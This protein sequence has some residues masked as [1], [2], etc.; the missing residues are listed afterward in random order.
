[1]DF[2]TDL[3]QLISIGAS[4]YGSALA[5]RRQRTVSRRNTTA[6]ASPSLSGRATHERPDTGGERA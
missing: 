3:L 6:P 5:I 1:L 4:L 2:I